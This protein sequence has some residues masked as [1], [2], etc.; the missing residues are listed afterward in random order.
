MID[1]SLV[2][3]TRS[4]WPVAP[5]SQS[6]PEGEDDFEATGIAGCILADAS[7]THHPRATPFRA[8]SLTGTARCLSGLPKQVA[9]DSSNDPLRGRR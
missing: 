7:S 3:R 5:S 6:A 9:R 4:R 2:T 1:S 8:S